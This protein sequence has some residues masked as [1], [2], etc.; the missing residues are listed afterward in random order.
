MPPLTIIL[1]YALNKLPGMSGAE[2]SR[3]PAWWITAC[4]L[5]LIAIPTVARVLPDALL[6]GITKVNISL[7][8]ALPF[9][10]ASGLVF[11]LGWFYRPQLAML[12]AALTVVVGIAYLKVIVFPALDA[13]Y[14]VRVF[15]NSNQPGVAE[16]CLDDIRRDWQYGLNYYAQQPIP[17][18]SDKMPLHIEMQ[19]GRLRLDTR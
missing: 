3:T 5:P 4:T 10:A 14:S 7:G 16:A 19:G 9:L 12:L 18:C 13:R 8:L 15:W 2:Q 1:A 17:S 11:A 6:S